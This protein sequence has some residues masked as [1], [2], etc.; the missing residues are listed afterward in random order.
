MDLAKKLLQEKQDQLTKEMITRDIVDSTIGKNE[1]AEKLK[2]ISPELE[3]LA[4]ILKS[5]F[6]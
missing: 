4:D 3:G 5:E 1:I 2:A 6:D